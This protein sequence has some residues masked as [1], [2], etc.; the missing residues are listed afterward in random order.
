[1]SNGTVEMV[2]QRE[3]STIE[4]HSKCYQLY[5]AGV[6]DDPTGG[7]RTLEHIQ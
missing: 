3:K 4:H 2:T 1:M 5:Y 6:V 7:E